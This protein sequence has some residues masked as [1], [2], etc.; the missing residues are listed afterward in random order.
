[1][2]A[3]PMSPAD[4]INEIKWLPTAFFFI[5]FTETI[6]LF[7]LTIGHCK[8]ETPS[9]WDGFQLNQPPKF[10]ISKPPAPEVSLTGCECE[11]EVLVLL[12]PARRWK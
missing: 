4:L 12:L 8:I 7:W 5:T 9:Y 3:I 11:S 2:N 10:Q 1:L 6:W